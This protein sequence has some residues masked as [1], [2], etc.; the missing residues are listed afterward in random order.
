MPTN[1]ALDDSLIDEAVRAGHHRT[2]REAVTAALREY[3][4]ARKRLAIFD[5]VGKVDYYEDYD[6]KKL[7]DRKP[8]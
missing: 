3:V 4:Q 5:W 8:R 7:R 2:K 6:P 1:L